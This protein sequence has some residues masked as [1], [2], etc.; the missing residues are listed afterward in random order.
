MANQ[1]RSEKKNVSTSDSGRETGIMMAADVQSNHPT[2][3]ASTAHLSLRL[4]IE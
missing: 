2:V 3:E 1:P 4:A